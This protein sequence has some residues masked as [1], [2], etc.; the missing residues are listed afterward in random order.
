MLL[1]NQSTFKESSLK[2]L[3]IINLVRLH[4]KARTSY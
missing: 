3:H 2:N 4:V 1:L